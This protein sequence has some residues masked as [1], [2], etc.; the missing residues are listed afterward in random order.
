MEADHA[1]LCTITDNVDF[2]NRYGP[3]NR[4]PLIVITDQLEIPLFILFSARKEHDLTAT[5]E[6]AIYNCCMRKSPEFRDFFQKQ[7]WKTVTNGNQLTVEK[8]LMPGCP[9][10]MICDVPVFTTMNAV[11][12]DAYIVKHPVD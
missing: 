3:D 2:V 12:P 4:N 7:V 1:T 6:V 5:D 11:Y 8:Q 10:I 9:M